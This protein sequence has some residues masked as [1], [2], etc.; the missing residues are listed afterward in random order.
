MGHEAHVNKA[1]D[2]FRCWR[3]FLL[4]SSKYKELCEFVEAKKAHHPWYHPLIQMWC[5]ADK[6]LDAPYYDWMYS[7]FSEDEF[8]RPYGKGSKLVYRDILTTLYPLFQNIFNDSTLPAFEQRIRLF[9]ELTKQHHTPI[10]PA[11]SSIILDLIYTHPMFHANNIDQTVRARDL[12]NSL[13]DHIQEHSS[14]LMIAVNPIGLSKAELKNEFAKYIDEVGVPTKS[15]SH[16]PERWK[17]YHSDKKCY[18]DA[19]SQ[20]L[21]AYELKSQHGRI[22]GYKAMLPNEDRDIKEFD[23]LIRQCKKVIKNAEIGSF[24]GDYGK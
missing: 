5:P 14:R 18:L 8:E 20:M 23:R 10:A 7:A 12:F 15:Q 24:P 21:T 16:I 19:L 1:I 6:G 11:S 3:K 13:I 4:F 22:D 9:F 2:R 17:I